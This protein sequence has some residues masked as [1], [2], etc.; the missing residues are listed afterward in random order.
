MSVGK[1]VKIEDLIA[2]YRAAGTINACMQKFHI[3]RRTARAL[4]E[5][6][7]EP[8]NLP[9]WPGSRPL[10]ELSKFLHD[11]QRRLCGHDRARAI[12]ANLS[13]RGMS[14]QQIVE[15]T[16]FSLVAV[17]HHLE[18]A[19]LKSAKANGRPPNGRSGE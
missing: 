10:A 7:G 17:A 1:R 4:L 16:G 18:T 3:S 8:L 12:C 19:R 5:A 14:E 13:E 15:A 11:D 2:C 9:P 6:A